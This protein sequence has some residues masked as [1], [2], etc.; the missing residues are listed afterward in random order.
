M[1]W[2]S[3][4]NFHHGSSGPLGNARDIKRKRLFGYMRAGPRRTMGLLGSAL[5]IYKRIDT[6]DHCDAGLSILGSDK[7]RYLS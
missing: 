7:S 1:L 3:T 6:T 4:N 2:I 5:L